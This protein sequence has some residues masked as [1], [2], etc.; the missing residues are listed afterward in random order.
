[1]FL[2][3]LVFFLNQQN[4]INPSIAT[5]KA[6]SM[7]RGREL[8]EADN[9]NANPKNNKNNEK[10]CTSVPGEYSDPTAKAT[11]TTGAASSSSAGGGMVSKDDSNSSNNNKAAKKTEKAKPLPP[12][13]MQLGIENAHSLSLSMHTLF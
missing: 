7:A 3:I 11:A 6:R 8:M 4:Q 1:M 5:I 13:A 12:K 10:K 9:N 2:L